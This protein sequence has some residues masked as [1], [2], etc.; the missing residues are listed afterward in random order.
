MRAVDELELVTIMHCPDI[1]EALM[2]RSVLEAMGIPVY[3]AG[4]FARKHSPLL[5]QV[6]LAMAEQARQALE[7][8]VPDEQL[9]EEAAEAAREAGGAA[10][11]RELVT[12]A[13]YGSKEEEQELRGL[14]E[15]EGIPVFLSN[16]FAQYRVWVY[17]EA[18]DWGEI[19]VPWAHVE[20]A[21]RVLGPRAK[22]D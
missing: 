4:E 5:L 20:Q 2:A 12:V 22:Q 21:R 14:L 17:P 13:A 6:P 8:G 9:A 10:G 18:G 15:Q 19:Q 7:S 16:D 1:V 3:L 11:E